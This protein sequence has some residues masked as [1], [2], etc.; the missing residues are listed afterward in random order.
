M[1]EAFSPQIQG[2]SEK[3]NDSA[4]T[5]NVQN[6]IEPIRDVS[7]RPLLER[8]VINMIGVAWLVLVMIE[9]SVIVEY[10]GLGYENCIEKIVG[11][12]RKVATG[13][14]LAGGGAEACGSFVRLLS[15]S[16]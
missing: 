14:V 15:G 13:R 9:K 16:A 12:Q 5:P 11:E 2:V 7:S 3:L 10:T 4:H 8:F 1:V 6:L